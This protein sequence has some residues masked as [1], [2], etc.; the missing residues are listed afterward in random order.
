VLTHYSERNKYRLPDYSRLDIAVRV[1]GEL[2]VKKI[3]HPYWIFSVYNVT[4]RQNV[5][6]VFFKNEGNI[7]R[8]YYLSVFGRAIPS[9]SLY[10][11][12]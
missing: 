3:L 1:S 10:F 11:D 12:F 9:L 7:V 6:S 4:G 8:G 2:K 5:Y